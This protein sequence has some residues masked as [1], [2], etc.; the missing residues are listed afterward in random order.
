METLTLGAEFIFDKNVYW[1]VN[2]ELP[3]IDKL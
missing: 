3:S 2:F 1:R